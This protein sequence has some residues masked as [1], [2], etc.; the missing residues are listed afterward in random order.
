M[1]KSNV[2]DFYTQKNMRLVF[3]FFQ[4]LHFDGH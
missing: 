3:E 2:V 1:S 4:M